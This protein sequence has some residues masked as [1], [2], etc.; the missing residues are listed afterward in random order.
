MEA[1]ANLCLGNELAVSYPVHSEM[2][3]SEWQALGSADLEC[4]PFKVS[5][6][7][8][9]LKLCMSVETQMTIV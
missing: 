9:Y 6:R 8:A 2:F 3:L 7:D 4:E 5:V 1:V